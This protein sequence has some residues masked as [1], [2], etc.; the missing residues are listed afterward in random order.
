LDA[1]AVEDANPGGVLALAG[2]LGQVVFGEKHR[3]HGGVRIGLETAIIVDNR[4]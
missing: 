3:G 4:A 1:H 2:K